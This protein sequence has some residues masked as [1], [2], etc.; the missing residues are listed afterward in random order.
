ML[1][2]YKKY[3]RTIF[4]IA[5]IVLTVYLIMLTFS[6]FYQIAAPIFLAFL[7][8]MAIEPLAKFINRR[9]IKKSIATAI[10]MLI[11]TV[12]ILGTL[13]GAGF[14]FAAQISGLTEKIPE[15]SEILKEQIALNTVYLEDKIPADLLQNMVDYATTFA[16]K[17]SQIAGAILLTVF[18]W[19]T[20]FSTFILNF[21]IG[22]ILAYFLS[23]EIESWKKMADEK[24]P[25]TFKYAYLFLK[26]NVVKGIGKYLKAQLKLITITF[27]LVLFGLV[28]LGVDNSF[29]IA[30]L[31]AIFD[32][33]PLLGVSTVFIP[34]IIY[35]FIVGQTTLAF[36]LIGLLAVVIVV[37]QITEPKITGDSLGVSAF[38]MLSF[39]II[40][41]SLFGVAGLILSP[42]L[43]ILIKALYE[44]GHLKKWIRVPP[45][46]AG[47]VPVH[48][49]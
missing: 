13:A 25:N 49:E 43:I 38:T 36:W 32:V 40:S 18:G 6:Y 30:V 37:R 20:S 16:E 4:D 24:V 48:I 45:K 5:M 12:V 1:A 28:A 31:A 19:I 3:W 34:W 33:L 39:M 22:L 46:D 27:V 44:Q 7:I 35:L 42:V 15:Y 8:F 23:I 17:G 21:I 11:F 29:A 26:D 47:E 9:G 10:S 41:L 14:I 2:Y